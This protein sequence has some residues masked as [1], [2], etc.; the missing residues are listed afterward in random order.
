MS[1]DRTAPAAA[2]SGVWL[3]VVGLPVPFVMIIL[4]LDFLLG[5]LSERMVVVQRGR[6]GLLPVAR[7]LFAT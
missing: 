4:P 5:Y 2:L 6:S 1:A 3:G 7:S